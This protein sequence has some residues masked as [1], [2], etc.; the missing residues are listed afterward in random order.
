MSQVCPAESALHTPVTCASAGGRGARPGSRTGLAG[1]RPQEPTHS[2]LRQALGWSTTS[3]FRFSRGRRALSLVSA[4]DSFILPTRLPS[5]CQIK[6]ERNLSIGICWPRNSTTRD[7]Q[8]SFT[9][10]IFS[11]TEADELQ[12]QGPRYL[13]RPSAP[14]YTFVPHSRLIQ[15]LSPA[16]R[17]RRKCPSFN[18]LQV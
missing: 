5:G 6:R 10:V 4:C 12:G 16:E 9:K 7:Q 3:E 15:R 18:A 14:A 8:E 2:R 13:G 1:G 17:L 11:Q